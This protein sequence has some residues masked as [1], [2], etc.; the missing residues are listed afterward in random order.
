M[1]L[2]LLLPDFQR[3]RGCYRR[4]ITSDATEAR[5]AGDHFTAWMKGLFASAGRAGPDR[6]LSARRIYNLTLGAASV[7]RPE[8]WTFSQDPLSIGFSFFQVFPDPSTHRID[9]FFR[10][11]VGLWKAPL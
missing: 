6:P 4:R 7:F 2:T 9:H 11:P 10:D 5:R 1:E 3:P 8:I